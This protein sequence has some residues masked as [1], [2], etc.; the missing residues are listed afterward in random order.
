MIINF[1]NNIKLNRLSY[2]LEVIEVRDFKSKINAYNKIKR[3]KITK[4]MGLLILDDS[5]F[6]HENN[7]SD[8]NISLYLI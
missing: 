4:E 8:G 6:A 1:I 5:N 3:M 2:L 7:Y